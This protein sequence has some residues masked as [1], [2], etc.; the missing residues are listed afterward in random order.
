M[1]HKDKYKLFDN[2]KVKDRFLKKVDQSEA[3]TKCHIWL[4]SKNK[5]GHGMFSVMGR[6]IPASRYSFMM[7][8][9]E[10]ANHEVVTQTCFNP[11]CVNPKH[12]EISDKRRLGKRISINPAQ[13]ESGS[14]NF[15][16]RLK[17]ERP[18]LVNKI[19][20]LINEINNPPTEVNFE[21]INPFVN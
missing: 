9:G 3:H 4:A 20:E 18:D 12:L 13:L 15:L 10:V 6:T 14:I 8:K 5:T 1:E 16:V 7:F 19:E 2:K 17:K 11:S 21:D